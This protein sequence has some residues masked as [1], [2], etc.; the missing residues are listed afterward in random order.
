MPREEVF[1][2]VEQTT[3]SPAMKR[4]HDH[5]GIDGPEL[6]LTRCLDPRFRRRLDFLERKRFNALLRAYLVPVGKAVAEKVAEQ[7]NDWLW[8]LTDV[9][10]YSM[11]TGLAHQLEKEDS[12]EASM[13]I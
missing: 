5:F 12:A 4:L 8:R 1:V 11:A 3:I 13:I 2:P 7:V 6:L 9:N 10:E